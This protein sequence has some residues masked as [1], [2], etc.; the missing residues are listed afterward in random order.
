MRR[1][2]ALHH[3]SKQL[4]KER[5]EIRRR[6][7]SVS[8]ASKAIHEA[9][10]N[11][12]HTNNGRHKRHGSQVDN[13]EYSNRRNLSRNLD[14]SFLSIDERGNMMPKIPEAALVAT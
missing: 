9:R 1:I 12:S 7:E 3:Q 8:A 11:V 10:S 6:R 14:S 5:S 2:N 4:E 13:L